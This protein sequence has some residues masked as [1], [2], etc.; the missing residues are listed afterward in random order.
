MN[1][2]FHI[3]IP[4]PCNENWQQMASADKGRFCAS[5][6]KNVHDFTQSSDR[7]IAEFLK[8]HNNTCGRFNRSQLN[9]DL[10]V[11]KDK[12]PSWFAVS[13]AVL[14]FLSLDTNRLVAQTSP[15]NMEQHYTENNGER[16]YN[17]VTNNITV[18]GIVL[19]SQE[20]PF[21]GVSVKNIRSNETTQTDFDGNF[22]IEGLEGDTLV[23][24]FIGMNSETIIVSSRSEHIITLEDLV[25]GGI[26]ISRTFFGRIFHSI[27]NWFQ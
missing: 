15:A 12:T 3:A 25:T 4:R 21:P 1:N 2:K 22:S 24:E 9:R 16:E 11:A 8:S 6:Q 26:E 10:I 27:G 19:D 14:S 13:A 5:C 7:Q 20:M 17:P 18:T 23:I